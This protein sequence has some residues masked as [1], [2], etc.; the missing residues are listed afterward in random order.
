MRIGSINNTAFEARIK[1]AKSDT[2]KLVKGTATALAG[3]ASLYTGL[4]ASEVLPGNFAKDVYNSV[5]NEQE[6]ANQEGLN[7][8]TEGNEN[9]A[10]SVGA[11]MLASLPTGL[12][13]TPLGSC[14]AAKAYLKVSD[15]KQIPN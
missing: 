13:I 9:S 7:K 10:I 14:S 12:T 15:N 3:T 11:T 1:M 2:A 8:Y 4:N 6:F 5:L